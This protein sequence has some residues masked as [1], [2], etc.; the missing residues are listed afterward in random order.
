MQPPATK[1]FVTQYISQGA[2]NPDDMELSIF[3]GYE[4]IAKR[5]ESALCFWA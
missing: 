5:Q 2:M 1:D 3:S 4:G